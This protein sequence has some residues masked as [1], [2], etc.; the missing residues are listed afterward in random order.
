MAEYTTL[1]RSLFFAEVNVRSFRT[2]VAM[3]RVKTTLDIPLG[4]PVYLKSQFA[5]MPA[6]HHFFPLH[7]TRQW[8]APPGAARQLS[9]RPQV[10]G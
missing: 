9:K 3:E 4:P 5:G 1:T 2:F 6:M 10:G 7:Q 8:I